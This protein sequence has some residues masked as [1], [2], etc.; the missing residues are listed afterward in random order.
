MLLSAKRN[1]IGNDGALR[2][3]NGFNVGDF[4]PAVLQRGLSPLQRAV[5]FVLELRHLLRGSQD[6]RVH[7]V[8]LL[9]S[10]FAQKFDLR[11]CRGNFARR[12]V[13]KPATGSE[14]NEN[15]DGDY[16]EVVLPRAA[17]IGPEENPRQN[18][19]WGSH[20]NLLE[21]RRRSRR[22][23]CVRLDRNRWWLPDCA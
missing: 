19:T 10:L 16:R 23:A 1:L 15:Q 2:I 9:I 4:K 21:F 5:K 14:Q 20:V 7:L 3:A 12:L 13:M 22:R 8:H 17:L 11:R 18:L 6:A